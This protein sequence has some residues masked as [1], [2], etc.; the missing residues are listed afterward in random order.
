MVF[1]RILLEG[2][3]V[4]ASLV[5]LAGILATTTAY[6]NAK[7]EK[8]SEGEEGEEG[9]EAVELRTVG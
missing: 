8:S 7:L 2:R 3:R 6:P 9:E 4:F 5:I 1:G